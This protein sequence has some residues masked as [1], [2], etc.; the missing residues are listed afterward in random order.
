MRK[1]IR[2]F[3]ISAVLLTLLF[4]SL[5]GGYSLYKQ[6]ENQ[7]V[8]NPVMSPPKTYALV[9]ILKS[10]GFEIAS[11]PFENNGTISA[12]VS[13]SLVLFSSLKDLKMQ[14][15]ALQL[16]TR[17]LKMEGTKPKEIDLRFTK[18]VVRY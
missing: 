18:V 2:L 4:I 3:V 9:K 13:G 1:K 14:V 7:P 8:N 11:P 10:A 12:S 5:I 17:S 16:V 6:S 15:K